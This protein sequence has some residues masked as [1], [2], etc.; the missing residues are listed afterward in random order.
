MVFRP[1]PLKHDGVKV[2]WDYDIPDKWK[3]IKFHGSSHHQAVFSMFALQ[4]PGSL[5]F[6]QHEHWMKSSWRWPFIRV[7]VLPSCTSMADPG[8]HHGR[9]GT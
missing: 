4:L 3:V 6:E 5:K 7:E 1:T 2:S 8:R 9:H